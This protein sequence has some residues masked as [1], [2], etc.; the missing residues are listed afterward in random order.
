MLPRSVFCRVPAGKPRNRTMGFARLDTLWPSDK[1]VL[2]VR[3]VNA[4][5][6][7]A[8]AGTPEQETFVINT[9]A[10]WSQVSNL[11]FHFLTSK[12]TAKNVDVLVNFDPKI[13]NQSAYGKNSAEKVS[14]GKWSLNV[15]NKEKKPEEKLAADI[16][17]EFGHALGLY[18]EHQMPADWPKAMQI[19]KALTTAYC[20]KNKLDFDTYW[21]QLEPLGPTKDF[22]LSKE[23]D[24]ASIMRYTIPN[25]IQVNPPL[26]P[27]C[28]KN[29]ALSPEDIAFMQ[30]LYPV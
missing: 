1:K 11:K 13:D 30:S 8:T 22:K 28:Q 12:D 3:F 24:N 23:Y 4:T 9:V 21:K 15:G 20:S 10:K 17:H 16:L 2:N 29:L 6:K 14:K 5:D 7:G 25:E 27:D 19:S 18:H 26:Y